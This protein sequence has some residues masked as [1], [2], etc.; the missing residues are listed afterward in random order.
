MNIE[1]IVNDLAS[2]WGV[3]GF[4]TSTMYGEFAVEVAK[5][6]VL[7]EREACAQLCENN[8]AGYSYGRHTQGSCLTEF[9]KES[10]G[11]HDGVT[12]AEAIRNRTNRD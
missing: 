11:R 4:D 9:P 3:G 10:G 7:L 1:K 8:C 6:V 5:R 12:Y 2:E